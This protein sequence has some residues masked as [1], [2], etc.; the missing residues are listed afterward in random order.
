MSE[1]LPETRANHSSEFSLPGW[2]AIQ[3]DLVM[4]VAPRPKKVN[5]QIRE[6]NDVVE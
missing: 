4:E 6:P 2:T 5:K 3:T 1:T